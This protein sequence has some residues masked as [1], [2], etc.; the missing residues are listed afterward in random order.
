MYIQEKPPAHLPSPLRISGPS[1]VSPK[2]RPKGRAI[3]VRHGTAQSKPASTMVT[4][5]SV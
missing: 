5:R 2:P 4:T 3:G 1:G